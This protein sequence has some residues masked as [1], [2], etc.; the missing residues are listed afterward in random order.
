[1][2][3]LGS[4]M[5]D[6]VGENSERERDREVRHGGEV[7]GMR[8]LSSHVRFE[9]AY[10]LYAVLLRRIRESGSAF[11]VL[12]TDIRASRQ[13]EL[14]NLHMPF[15]GC[16]DESRFIV[17]VPGVYIYPSI[18]QLGHRLGVALECGFHHLRDPV[19][20]ITGGT[21]GGARKDDHNHGHSIR[22]SGWS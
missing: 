22:N 2:T 4:R 6:Y 7:A 5:T 11:I 14:D 3:L 18:Q 1:M 8:F 20:R 17:Y 13:E 10:D 19:S 15:Q 9:Y 16:K 21:N 12:G